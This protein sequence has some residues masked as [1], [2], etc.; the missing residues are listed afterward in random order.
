MRL[1]HVPGGRAFL[2]A[3]PSEIILDPA[4]HPGH[5]RSLF[6][7]D[8]PLHLEIGMGKGQF[9]MGMAQAN[10]GINYLGMERATS[11]AVRALQRLLADPRPNVRLVLGCASELDSCFAEG[12]VDRLLLNFSD[13]WPKKAHAKR[14]LTHA[15]FLGRYRTVLAPGG[16]LHFKTDNRGLFEFSLAHL[17]QHGWVLDDVSLDLHAAEPEDNVRT[18]YEEAFAAEGH[19]IYR[20]VAKAG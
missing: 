18:E 15:G 17:S 6:G 13:P 14:R 10:P 4:A 2:E 16:E 3:H 9:V 5:W 11:V 7:N 1:R 12:E 8:R 19:P 20:L